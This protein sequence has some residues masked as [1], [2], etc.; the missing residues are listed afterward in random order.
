VETGDSLSVESRNISLALLVLPI[1]LLSFVEPFDGGGESFGPCGFA[2]GASDPF[3]V[4]ALLRRGEAV[5]E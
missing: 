5:E 1:F 4:V 3:D 2:F